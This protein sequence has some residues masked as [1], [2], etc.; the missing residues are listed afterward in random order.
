MTVTTDEWSFFVAVRVSG[1]FAGGT[2]GFFDRDGS[3][4]VRLT[5]H[6]CNSAGKD[7]C[8]QTSQQATNQK[9]REIVD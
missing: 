7:A 6:K 3:V 4:D 1:S 8:D 2:V 5:Q 9:L